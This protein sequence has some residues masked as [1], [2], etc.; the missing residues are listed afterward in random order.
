MTLSYRN[1]T[2]SLALPPLLRAAPN[3]PTPPSNPASALSRAAVVE[4]V[5]G[6][7]PW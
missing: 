3:T 4:V 6:S 7:V 5:A 1:A 2:A